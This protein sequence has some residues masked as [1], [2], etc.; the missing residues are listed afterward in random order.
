MYNRPQTP[1]WSS[2][3]YG[4]GFPLT[5]PPYSPT[6]NRGTDQVSQLV[7]KLTTLLLKNSEKNEAMH[8]LS[9]QREMYPNLGSVIWESPAAVASLLSEIITAIPHVTAITTIPASTH[10]SISPD[11]TNRVCNAMTLFQSI[12]GND[13]VRDAFLR[14]NLPVYLFPF[15]HTTNQ[16]TECEH[17]KVA[18]LGVIGTIAMSDSPS[19]LLYLADNDFLPLCLRILKFGQDIQKILA[20][21]IIQRILSTQK[22]IDSLNDKE[23]FNSLV[24]ILTARVKDLA[25]NF[26]PRLS[27]NICIAFSYLLHAPNAEER[28]KA[29]DFTP[30]GS[31]ELHPKCDTTFRQLH[32]KL[33]SINSL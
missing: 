24:I 6:T 32:A 31:I 2:S 14:A 12:A 5:N 11:L 29:F 26:N 20:A 22:A 3:S 15:L 19:A 33:T 18:A 27:R 30:L 23:K 21:Y 17:F 16:S 25:T 7:K 1:Q 4:I 28:L 8:T 10:S 13:D 9:A